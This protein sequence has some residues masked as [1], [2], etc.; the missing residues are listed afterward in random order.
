MADTHESDE[1]TMKWVKHNDELVE[2]GETIVMNASNDALDYTADAV[3]NINNRAWRKMVVEQ[4]AVEMGVGMALAQY[5]I[6]V[7]YKD[8]EKTMHK[9]LKVSKEVALAIRHIY[10]GRVMKNIRKALD[11]RDK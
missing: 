10:I 6:P 3:E 1:E 5:L 4:Q 2:L 9:K 7:I 8:M 11:E